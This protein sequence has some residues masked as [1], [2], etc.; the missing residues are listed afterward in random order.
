MD[1]NAK[2]K[3]STEM[4]WVTLEICEGAL[5]YRA[6]ISSSSIERALEKIAGRGKI[7]RKVRLIFPIDSEN[8][9]IPEVL[10]LDKAA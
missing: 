10:S 1:L 2:E 5:T 7:G 4:I 6:R 3:T 9:F 8:L